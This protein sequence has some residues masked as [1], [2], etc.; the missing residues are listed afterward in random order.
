MPNITKTN[1]AKIDATK[2]EWNAKIDNSFPENPRKQLSVNPIICFE[3]E[4]TL[5]DK[6]EIHDQYMEDVL[7]SKECMKGE[8]ASCQCTASA[9]GLAK[10]AAFM[11]N[12]GELNGQTLFSKET[13]HQLHG[14]EKIAL[15]YG[16]FGRKLYTNMTQGGL[17]HFGWEQYKDGILK[18]GED[19]EEKP[20]ELNNCLREGYF[21]WKGLGGSV[22]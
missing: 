13:W 15:D 17:G 2:T 18:D 22:F 9:R 12:Q 10:L 21:G 14:E 11:A 20:T 4:T 6:D 8:T 5:T 16:Y 1:K 19:T 7:F 3:Y